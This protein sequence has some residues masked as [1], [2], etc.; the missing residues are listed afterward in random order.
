MS[1][2]PGRIV[3]AVT[4]DLPRPRTLE[5]LSAPHFGAIVQTIRDRLDREA[6]L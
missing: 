2:R 3:E 4:I 5:M 6:F 1:P